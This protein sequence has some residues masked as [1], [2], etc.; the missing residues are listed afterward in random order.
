MYRDI[1][2]AFASENALKR[3]FSAVGRG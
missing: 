1:Y 2:V 3:I